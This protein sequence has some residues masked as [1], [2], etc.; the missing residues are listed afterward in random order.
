MDTWKDIYYRIVRNPVAALGLASSLLTYLAAEVVPGATWPALLV[1]VIALL[2]R[3]VAV[4]A[5]EVPD[6]EAVARAE[7]YNLGFEEAMVAA[8]GEAAE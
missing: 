1:G 2:Q 3:Q 8:I 7:G 6:I 5:A 4:P